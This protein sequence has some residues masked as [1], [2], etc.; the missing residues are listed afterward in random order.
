[1]NKHKKFFLT[2]R[3]KYGIMPLKKEGE[4]LIW[5][6]FEYNKPYHQMS[7]LEK[8]RYEYEPDTFSEEK[9]LDIFELIETEVDRCLK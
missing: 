3:K 9:D 8:L 6:E 7:M 2:N 4:K 1:M 5:Y